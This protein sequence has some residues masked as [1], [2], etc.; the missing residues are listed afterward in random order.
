MNSFVRQVFRPRTLLV[1][2]VLSLLCLAISGP[3]KDT[4]GL[5]GAVSWI[6]FVGL[7]V[8]L[9]GLVVVAA[10]LLARRVVSR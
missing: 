7:W 3:T 9:V 8:G 2:A 1:L 6:T 5:E 10:G 4:S